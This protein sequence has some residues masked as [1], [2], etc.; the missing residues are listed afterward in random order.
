MQDLIHIQT[1]LKEILLDSKRDKNVQKYLCNEILP[2]YDIF[3]E[4][5]IKI[6]KNNHKNIADFLAFIFDIESKRMNEILSKLE[7][8]QNYKITE[9]DS[10]IACLNTKI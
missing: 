1:I 7:I 6:D 4:N 8:Y 3:R 5:Y 10:R 9:K 2:K